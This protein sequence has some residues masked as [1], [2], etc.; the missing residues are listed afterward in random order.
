MYA[1]NE[2]PTSRSS[3]HF[4]ASL[5]PAPLLQLSLYGIHSFD[6][7]LTLPLLRDIRWPMQAS[8][9]NK[10]P[11]L[12]AAPSFAALVD[13]T[14][15]LTE[16]WFG[17]SDAEDTP[18]TLRFQV[19]SGSIVLEAG[20]GV[21]ASGSGS[22]DASATAPRGLLLPYVARGA[23]RFLSAAG[24][25]SDVT[26]TVTVNDNGNT[27]SGGAQAAVDTATIE[28]G[29]TGNAPSAVP[30]SLSTNE[31]VALD[32]ELAGSDADGDGLAFGVVTPPQHGTLG[33]ALGVLRYTP[34]PGYSGA[35]AFTFVAL[36]GVLVSSPAS[37]DITIESVNHAPVAG[38]LVDRVLPVGVA[39]NFSIASGFTDSDG[40][41]L[42]FSATGLPASLVLAGATG[43]ISG[44]PLQGEIGVHP[45]QI[46]ASDGTLTAT[47]SFS[48]T[49]VGEDIFADGFED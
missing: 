14:S 29:S 49:I 43:A 22:N 35:D 8:I 39:A 4:S 48:L 3:S 44:T 45:I 41:T 23:V 42:S 17:D 19:D 31:G 10:P 5:T 34:E 32:I 2:F 47:A 9:P 28:V 46:T 30:Q 7:D 24:D 1:S 33:G 21:T 6:D 27:G 18:L 15:T 38:T 20:D 25:T 37:I 36:D 26:L 13:Q 12:D 16:L 11:Y 40:D